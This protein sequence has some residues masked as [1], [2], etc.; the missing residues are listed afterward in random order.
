MKPMKYEPALTMKVVMASFSGTPRL[1]RAV[2]MKSD[3]LTPING[4]A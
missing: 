2:T 4:T 1:P 3:T